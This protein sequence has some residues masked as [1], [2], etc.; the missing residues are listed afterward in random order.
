[1]SGIF[2]ADLEGMAAYARGIM[3]SRPADFVIGADYLRRWWV[4]PRNDYCN[5][6]LHEFL[7]SD[8]DRALHDHPWAST[9]FI[10]EGRYIEHT[11]DG[12]FERNAGDV[13]T[14]AAEAC[15][16][17]ELYPGERAVTLFFTGPKVRDWGFACPKGWVPWWEFVDDRDAGQVGAGCGEFA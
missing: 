11:P 15:H 9:S 6:Y 4:L 1:M 10:I 2:S 13:V 5:V 7:H 17:V 8:D 12:A 3:A 16:R 14:R